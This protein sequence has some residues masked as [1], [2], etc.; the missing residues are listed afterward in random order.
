MS[1]RERTGDEAFT[2]GQSVATLR[3][4]WTT[5]YRADLDPETSS[6]PPTWRIVDRGRVYDVL[7]AFV[8]DR[9]VGIVL[10]TNARTQALEPG[11]PS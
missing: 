1:R 3:V 6:V 2:A 11:S 10:L 7:H 5:A 4:E 8:L 9:R